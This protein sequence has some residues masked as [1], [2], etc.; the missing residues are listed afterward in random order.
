[1]YGYS[2]L[3]EETFESQKLKDWHLIITILC[4]LYMSKNVYIYLPFL[5]SSWNKAGTPARSNGDLTL[6]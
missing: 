2:D 6:I 3:L 5:S 4:Y 1:M